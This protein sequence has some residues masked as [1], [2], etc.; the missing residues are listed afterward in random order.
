MTLD[1]SSLLLIAFPVMCLF[2]G[3]VYLMNIVYRFFFRKNS[4]VMAGFLFA[5]I[6]IPVIMLCSWFFGIDHWGIYLPILSFLLGAEFITPL[7]FYKKYKLSYWETHSK[8]WAQKEKDNPAPKDPDDFESWFI[9]KYGKEYYFS[10]WCLFIIPLLFE[11]YGS[12]IAS[13]ET[14]HLIVTNNT[15]MVVVDIRGNQLFCK[16]FNRENKSFD[17]SLVILNE[18]DYSNKLLRQV[19]TGVLHFEE[20]STK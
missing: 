20:P 9:L 6:G 18:G 2:V 4:K 8:L 7:L 11:G 10:F 12:Q 13:R 17:N 15:E 19:S 16:P 3:F 14:T 1:F 5:G